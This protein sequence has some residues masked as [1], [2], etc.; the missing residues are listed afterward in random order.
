[1][2][3]RKYHPFFGDTNDSTHVSGDDRLLPEEL[4]DRIN[5]YI[6]KRM[7]NDPEEYKKDIENSSTFNALIRKEIREG[8]L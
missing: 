5:K 2:T 6:E 8:N 4:K 3:G 7:L 1:M